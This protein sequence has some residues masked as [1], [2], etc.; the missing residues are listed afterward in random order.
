[1]LYAFYKGSIDK[2]RLFVKLLD[3][4]IE[5]DVARKVVL[6]AAARKTMGIRA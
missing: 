5:V 6:V 4:G 2:E 1:L 3:I